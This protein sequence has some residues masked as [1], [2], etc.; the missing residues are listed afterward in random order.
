MKGRSD[1]ETKRRIVR[2]FKRTFE[3]NVWEVEK[4]ELRKRNTYT[5]AEKERSGK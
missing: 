4:A 1:E 5:E 3:G 2:I